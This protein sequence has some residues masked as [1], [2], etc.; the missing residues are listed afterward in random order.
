MFA[1][2]ERGRRDWLAEALGSRRVALF[3]ER[4]RFGSAE[5]GLVAAERRCGCVMLLFVAD[6]LERALFREVS[7]LRVK[8]WP[9]LC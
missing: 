7:G 2:Q 9:R 3:I 8:P 1:G 4:W 5:T 6:E